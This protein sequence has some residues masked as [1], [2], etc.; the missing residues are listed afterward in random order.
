MKIVVPNCVN[1][2][3]TGDGGMLV[4]RA[5]GEELRLDARA[6]A[7]WNVLVSADTLDDALGLRFRQ[8]P[9]TPEQEIAREINNF[10]AKLT[11]LELIQ[12]RDE[13]PLLRMLGALFGPRTT[14]RLAYHI[15]ALQERRRWWLD[16]RFDR[17]F[18]TDTSG[19][20]PIDR[21]EF[22]GPS[23]RF[24][25]HYEPTP[26]RILRVALT[27]AVATPE[28]FVFVDFGSGKGRALLLASELP[29]LRVMGVELSW[30]LH[31]IAMENIRRF[32]SGR[33]RCADVTSLYVDATAFELPEEDL[34]LYFY[35]PFQGPVFD[36]V[37]DRIAQSLA[38]RPRRLV[39]VAYSSRKDQMERIAAQKF[40][41][42]WRIVPLQ[43]DPTR[44]IRHELFVFTND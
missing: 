20:V 31:A 39:I 2:T 22:G 14:A 42:H 17:R 35:T 9:G 41:T 36:A 23:A 24:A 1:A 43:P 38:A 4:N 28:H 32:R 29:F 18:G 37:I 30:K 3:E 6:M 15:D 27:A 40:V 44:L 16:A 26:E 12:I 10:I 33:Q 25:V 8:H 11:V 13:R 21:L 19:I 5:T 34:V 7:L